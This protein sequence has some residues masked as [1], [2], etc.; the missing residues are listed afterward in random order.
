M[1]CLLFNIEEIEALLAI[2]AGKDI[3]KIRYDDNNDY[4]CA[5]EPVADNAHTR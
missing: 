1:K 3:K 4:Y 5:S 2:S